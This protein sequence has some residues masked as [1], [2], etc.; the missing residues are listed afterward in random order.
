M[1]IRIS[2]AFILL[3]TSSV[4]AS[5][6]VSLAST[7]PHP[8]PRH[9]PVAGVT[10]IVS[11]V[12][13][14]DYVDAFS[15]VVIP[16]DVATGNDVFTLS[17]SSS[18][19]IIS[20]N[21]GVALASGLGWYLKYTLNAS[22]GWG[23]NNSG[24]NVVAM[25]PP[26]GSPLPAPATP[27]RFVSPARFRYAWNT[28]TFGY[29]FPFYTTTDWQQEIDRI[30]LWGINAP[31]LPIG[32]EAAE[33]DVYS[34]LGL[35][36]D[37]MQAWW[38]GH[39]HLPWQRMANIKKIAGP[40]PLA[41]VEAQRSLGQTVAAM[42]TAV[43]MTPVLNGFAG[44]VPDAVRRVRPSANIS[45][46]SDWGGVGC[47]ES[48]VALLEP[49][50]PL[51]PVLGAALNARV[52]Q[53]YGG[54]D[55]ATAPLFNADTFNEE[56]PSSGDDAYLASWN[57]AIYTA[58]VTTHSASVFVLQAWAFHGGFWTE[59]RVKAYLSPVPLTKMLVLDLNTETGPVYQN[60]QGFF[61]HYFAWCGLIVFGG[62]RGVYGH[63][64]VL[65]TSIFDARSAYPNL[66]GVGITPEAIDQ[67]LPAFDV[68][69]ETG[70]RNEPVADVG[71][72]LQGYAARRYGASGT[73][74]TL[75]EAAYTILRN[76]SY[77]AGGPDL[78]IYEK[79][80]K[81]GAAMSRG[82]NATGALE[83]AR[84]LLSAAAAMP[85]PTPSS[86][87][88][89]I[90]D[91]VR[92][93]SAALHSDI[94]SMMFECF[95]AGASRAGGA[96]PAAAALRA[97]ATAATQVLADVDTVLGSDENF[98]LGGFVERARELGSAA[99]ATDL[100]VR[101][102]KM[103]VSTWTED[104]LAFGGLINDYSSRNG[105]SGLVG[106][107]YSPRWVLF[108]DVLVNAT[109]SGTAPD[110][111]SWQA[112]NALLEAAFVADTS[113]VWPVAPPAG[114]DALTAAN[115]F[116]DK[117]IPQGTSATPGFTPFIGYSL[118]PAVPPPTPTQNWLFRGTDLAAV[119]SDC[120][121]LSEPKLST[122]A[123]CQQ[124]CVDD[125]NCNFVNWDGNSVWCV[126]RTCQD[127]L[128]AVLSP[129]PGYNAWALNRTGGGT[130][131]F[132][133]ATLLQPGAMATVCAAD[134]LCVAFDSLGMIVEGNWTKVV[135]PGATV[136]WR[137]NTTH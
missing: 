65:A 51:F 62:R 137:D 84:L 49:S 116:L 47:N 80:P 35:T 126:F 25:L 7:P 114:S 19:I 55:S 120:P 37:E 42:M 117:W 33:W 97:L 69:L 3:L 112:A 82:T 125:D 34:N 81:L 10:A 89:D 12:L 57:A 79:M 110:W 111:K 85:L 99:G 123:A 113:T 71:V 87:M 9:D 8:A 41:A 70:W 18:P 52:L 50:D 48:C 98:L 30:A 44:H 31:L 78:S 24:N 72:W 61:G 107:Y 27:G 95:K 132:I 86:L 118:V 93:A 115:E 106:S 94:V 133:S 73:A 5:A 15:F 32:L 105:W 67:C 39:A 108:M 121:F 76:A 100:F 29:S 101:D 122:L 4:V 135:Q 53:L 38:S 22:W 58:M 26:I 43:G 1:M 75:V 124:G 45:A 90:I 56:T 134:P 23:F 119:S 68:L 104:G 66:A 91:L 28:C 14:V 46:S 103:L 64:D 74:A 92:G 54:G 109:A 16:P 6:S 128:T 60:Y 88:Y 17:S 127:P 96:V 129:T 13:G 77:R 63:L 136:W 83:A 36:A 130:G 11:R 21:T 40:L 131:G 59:D 2:C 20:G 102:A